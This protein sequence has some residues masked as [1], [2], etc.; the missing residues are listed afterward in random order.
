[1]RDKIMDQFRAKHTQFLIA[2]DIAARGIDVDDLAFV[3]QYQLPDTADFY[4][5]RSGR[6]GRAGKKGM[7]LTFVFPEEEHKLRAMEAELGMSFIAYEK[8]SMETLEG[9]SIILWSNRIVKMKLSDIDPAIRTKVLQ[10]FSKLSKDQLIDRLI[11]DQLQM[12]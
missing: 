1:I 4:T 7:S 9:S 10:N 12:G 5:H 11:S 2:T 3:M 8:P 6:T